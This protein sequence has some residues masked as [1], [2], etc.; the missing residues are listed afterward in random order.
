MS[1]KLRDV[2]IWV[3]FDCLVASHFS[4]RH[5]HQSQT[6]AVVF[7]KIGLTRSS[8]S[9]SCF[10]HLL[11]PMVTSCASNLHGQRSIAPEA[12]SPS[13]LIRI[14]LSS[15]IL[16]MAN[17]FSRRDRFPI[18]PVFAFE[19]EPAIVLQ[20]ACAIVFGATV[21]IMPL[22]PFRHWFRRIKRKRVTLTGIP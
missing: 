21:R 4:A 17:G 20:S 11:V 5:P 14:K 2:G 22:L 18:L 8:I 15:T 1:D 13:L 7:F 12:D 10:D 19:T 6:S 9:G 3:A 16:A